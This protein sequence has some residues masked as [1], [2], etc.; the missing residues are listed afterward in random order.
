MNKSLSPITVVLIFTPVIAILYLLELW[1]PLIIFFTVFITVT[2]LFGEK[3]KDMTFVAFSIIGLFLI[4]FIL[5]PIA[6]LMYQALPRLNRA[7]SDTGAVDAIFVSMSG[8]L[9]ATAIGLILGI[10]LAYTLARKDFHGKNFIEGL[11]DLPMVVPHPVAG[12]ALLVIFSRRGTL[13]EPL[14]A[15]GINFVDAF[16]GIVVAMLFVSI[17]FIVNQVRE[18]FEDVD[19]RLEMVAMSLGADRK[20]AFFTVSLPLVKRNILSG[21]VMGWARAISEF[22]AI[23][24]I[25]FYPHTAPVYIYKVFTEIG[26]AAAQPVAALL[27]I[28]TLTIFIILRAITRGSSLYDKD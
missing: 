14:S 24:V 22:G 26:L 4:I 3:E 9:V 10:P 1:I 8:A 28:V 7:L 16:P 27:L 13:G 12:I 21:A 18:G 20:K 25:A 17:P 5:L 19:P 23:A 11:I 15:A 6:E 2:Y